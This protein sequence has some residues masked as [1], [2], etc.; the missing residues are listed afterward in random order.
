MVTP[1]WLSSYVVKSCVTVLGILEFL[2][3]SLF[4]IPP[5]VSRPNDNGMTSTKRTSLIISLVSPDRIAAFKKF[6]NFYNLIYNIKNFKLNYLNSS[7]VSNSLVWINTLIY[8]LAIKVL[9]QHSLN[10]WN[11]SWTSNKNNLANLTFI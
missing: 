6:S 8:F 3:I 5:T 4:M 9:F 10:L 2:S 7:T 11:T 1:G